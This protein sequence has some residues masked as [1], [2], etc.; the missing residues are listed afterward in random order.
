MF[1]VL[2]P[3]ASHEADTEVFSTKQEIW[4][5]HLTQSLQQ[6]QVTQCYQNRDGFT[7][8]QQI[9]WREAKFRILDC[10]KNQPVVKVTYHII[11]ST[12]AKSSHRHG[13]PSLCGA[14]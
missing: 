2:E 4:L 10:L 3:H 1:G 11:I 13:N 9:T 5:S 8:G 12:R 7:K 14:F 6:L